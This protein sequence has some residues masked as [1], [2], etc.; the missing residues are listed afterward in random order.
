MKFSKILLLLIIPLVVVALF[1]S[2]ISSVS[3]VLLGIKGPITDGNL[4]KFSGTAG[5]GED[6]GVAASNVT[7]N[8]FDATSA[9]TVHDDT[10][11]EYVVGSKWYDVTAD[12]GYVCLDNSDGNAVWIEITSLGT[13]TFTGLTDTPANYTDEGGKYVKVNVGEDALE[14]GTVAGE[15]N[16]AS[17]IGAQ[18]EIFKQKTGIDLEFRTLKADSSKITI[19]TLALGG[20]KEYQD[21]VTLRIAD[22][23]DTTE[24]KGQYWTTESVYELDSV[25]VQM[26]RAGSP[27]DIVLEVYACGEDHK[28]TGN[29]LATATTNCN[30]ITTGS[31]GELVTFD[32]INVLLE[33]DTE[34]CYYMKGA[35]VS[36]SNEVK[37]NGTTDVLANSAH[38][39]STDSGS[40]W[41]V[42]TGNDCS[43]Q[44]WATEAHLNYIK[45]DVVPSEIRLDDLKATEDNTD[46]N[47]STSAH[48]LMPKLDNIPTHYFNGQGALTTPPGETNTASN[49]GTG[50]EIFKQKTGV[51][52]EFRKIE[53][54]SNQIEISWY[55]EGA[56]NSEQSYTVGEDNDK[57]VSNVAW[58]AQTFTTTSAHNIKKVSIRA[59][60]SAGLPDDDLHVSI[61]AT[62]AGKPTGSVLVSSVI[63][64]A[65]I[66]SGLAWEDCI[67]DSPYD[68]SDATMYAIVL[69]SPSSGGAGY[70]VGY[71]ITG[72]YT[73]GTK[74]SSADSGTNWNIVSERDLMFNIY[75]IGVTYEDQVE[76]DVKEENIKLDDLGSPDDNTDNDASTA[77]H[78]LMPKLPFSGDLLSTTTVAFNAD[79]DTTLYTVPTGKRCV[80]S[81]AIVVAAGDAGATTTVSI[82]QNTAE[83][84]F[85]PANTLS[86]LDA[87][88]DSVILIPIPNTTP[89]KIK[90]YAADTVIEAQ[91]ASQSGAAGNT[92][93]LFGILY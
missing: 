66:G 32:V 31:E 22:V 39:Y 19:E 7:K 4:I 73:V 44:I 53:A 40:T 25:K 79:A 71:D 63:D 36:G 23:D 46:L 13:T 82:G 80:L 65:D 78:G 21:A 89:L 15:S 60:R 88:Y 28:P 10:D 2:N 45:F 47:A 69:S 87:Q 26:Y 6:A 57:Y 27:G 35:T 70:R 61:Y 52:L 54:G 68:L 51:D 92:I 24:R 37:Y 12:K 93:Y 11:E 59:K 43:F 29:I 42:D 18:I 14:F 38:L 58:A 81:H 56:Y 77:A 8:K 85:V 62:S 86:N 16:T 84:D 48:G 83:T 67:F 41:T 34:Y 76:I 55:T 91:I 1:G 3:T 9:P 5:V 17:N 72:E 33:I 30:D 74:V 50:A 64:K 49:I 75:S 20:K 90:S